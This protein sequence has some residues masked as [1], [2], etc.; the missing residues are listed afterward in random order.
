[1]DFDLLARR[2]LG[3]QPRGGAQSTGMG[4]SA[5]NPPRVDLRA[6]C[7]KVERTYARPEKTYRTALD[8]LSNEWERDYILPCPP[9][10]YESL[11]DVGLAERKD[12]LVWRAGKL[13]PTHTLY[14]R[15]AKAP[16]AGD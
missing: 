12:F 10:A 1:M 3:I 11:V 4:D 14:R 13:V 7:R 5:A 16:Q 15:S 6:V 9:H 8:S 2:V